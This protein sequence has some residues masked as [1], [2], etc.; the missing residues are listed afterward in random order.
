MRLLLWMI[1]RRIRQLKKQR[2][3]RMS[4]LWKVGVVSQTVE[5]KVL[6][7]PIAIGFLLLMQT[8]EF[9]NRYA[10]K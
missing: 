3:I 2:N 7:S 8:R 1:V 5:I 9:L 10:M 4:K 6:K